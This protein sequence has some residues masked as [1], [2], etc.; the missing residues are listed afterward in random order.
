MTARIEHHDQDHRM[1]TGAAPP[2]DLLGRDV[3]A[4]VAD[5]AH[6]SRFFKPDP[7]PTYT[8]AR[9]YARARGHGGVSQPVRLRDS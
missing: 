7:V 6:S 5:R 1:T 4:T 2:A 9:A 8:Y 3:T